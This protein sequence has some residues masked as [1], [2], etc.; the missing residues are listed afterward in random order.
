MEKQMGSGDD[1]VSHSIL[2]FGGAAVNLG[3]QGK[4][5]THILKT[6]ATYKS[7]FTLGA[8]NR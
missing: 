1:N 2:S 8:A 6:M 5:G 4:V 3:L 7:T